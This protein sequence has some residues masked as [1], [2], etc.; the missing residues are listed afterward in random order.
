VPTVAQYPYTLVGAVIDEAWRLALPGW[1]CYVFVVTV[2]VT[3]SSISW[4]V[5]SCCRLLPLRNRMRRPALPSIVSWLLLPLAFL[6]LQLLGNQLAR[7]CS[8]LTV[9][10]FL[11]LLHYVP[12]LPVLLLQLLKLCFQTQFQHGAAQL[13]SVA[14]NRP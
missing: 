8:A 2:S 6:L 4:Q 3:V 9:L 7:L 14:H 13:A 1:G 11:L 10:C 12:G 5:A